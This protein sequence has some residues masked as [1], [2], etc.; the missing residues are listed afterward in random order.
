MEKIT[1]FAK[2]LTNFFSIYLPVERGVSHNTIRAY[3][4][5]FTLLIN[6]MEKIKKINADRL[7][8]NHF[9]RCVILDFLDWI[10]KDRKNTHS[11][12]NNRLAAIQSFFRYLQYED[13]YRI[14]LWQEILSIKSKHHTERSFKHLSIEGVKLLLE[15]IDYKTND[16]MRDLAML[17]LLYDSGARSQELIDL[18][19]SSLSLNK[20]YHVTLF[21]KGQKRRIVPLQENQVV[22]LKSYMHKRRLDEMSNNQRP[23]FFNYRGEKLSNAGLSY[24]INQYAKA[25]RVIRPDLIPD[26]ISPHVFRHS[27]AMHLLQAGVNI[28]YIRDILGHVSIQTTEIYA[29]ADSKQ[30][31]EALEKAYVNLI[32]DG[33]DKGC[34]E[35]DSNLL[36]WLKSFRK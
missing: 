30:K 12:R 32:P 22:L 13:S 18:T 21:G 9:N 19:P 31:R 11:T 28:V 6:Y 5:T 14:A 34:W 3:S 7:T 23:L 33:T 16:G 27:K 24:I 8:L 2:F 25:A 36:S 10:Q 15:Q 4:T 29:R 20:P 35:N 17:S 1:D 26:R